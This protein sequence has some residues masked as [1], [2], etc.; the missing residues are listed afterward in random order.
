MAT[1][2]TVLRTLESWG[3]SDVVL[4]FF[5]IFTIAFAVFQR[6]HIFGSGEETRTYNVILSTILGLVVVI[7]H[8]LGRYPR[9]SDPV[10][11]INAA[12]PN[13]AVLLVAVVMVFLLLG[14]FG[15]KQKWPNKASGFIAFICFIIVGY[16]FGAA[17]GWFDDTFRLDQ[18]ISPDTQALLIV[19]GVFSLII[20][21]ITRNPKAE[22][23]NYG[24]KFFEAIGD[25]FEGS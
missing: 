2:D 4:P 19:V 10:E 5:L 7:P 1:F 23:K 16:I 21:F 25:M 20:W 12:L 18:W 24:K 9:G 14:L 3:L 13:I 22:P 8:V 11:I 15:A 6:A 17:A